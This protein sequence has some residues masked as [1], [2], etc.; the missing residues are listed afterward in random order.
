MGG[1]VESMDELRELILEVFKLLLPLL[2]QGQL[3][4]IQY[5]ATNYATVLEVS[6]ASKVAIWRFPVPFE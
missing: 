5:D 1:L 6:K 4:G 2:E 3:E